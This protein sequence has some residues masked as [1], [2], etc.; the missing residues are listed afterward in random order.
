MSVKVDICNMAL[1]ALNVAKPIADVDTEKSVEAQACRLFYDP[2]VDVVLRAFPWPFATAMAPLAL[3]AAQP[4]QEWA[5]AYRLPVDCLFF[6]RILS[7]SRTDTRDSIV[8]RRIARDGSGQLV[9]TDVE[10]AQAEWTVRIT[11]PEEFSADFVAA[12]QFYLAWR[13]APL[14]TGGDPFKLGQAARRDY[15]LALSFAAENA[16]AE[17]VADIPPESEFV[18]GRD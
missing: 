2:A 15:A 8:P 17:E 6:R 7:G 12:L 3:V 14:V 10:Q 13:I 4:T 11:N 16:A 18:R 1:A 5:F 9:Y